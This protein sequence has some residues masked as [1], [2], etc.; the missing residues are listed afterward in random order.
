VELAANKYKG[1]FCWAGLG[2]FKVLANFIC[3]F[4]KKIWGLELEADESKD[5]KK[6][7]LKSGVSSSAAKKIVA[8]YTKEAENV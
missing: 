4:S 2:N 6:A 5:L 7:L 8:H 1:L 3:N